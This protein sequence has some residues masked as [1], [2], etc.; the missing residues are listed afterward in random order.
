[1]GILASNGIIH[2]IDTVLQVPAPT[3]T[4]ADLAVS[5]P[6]QYSTL[7]EALTRADLVETLN[8]TSAEFTVFAPTNDAFDDL[9]N[10]LGVSSV[11]DIDSTLLSTVLYHVNQGIVKSSDLQDGQ[12]LT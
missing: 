9:L 6:D 7:V 8:D 4:I 12:I 3:P 11:N 5:L 1:M 10:Q 2:V